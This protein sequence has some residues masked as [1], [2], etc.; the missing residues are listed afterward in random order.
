MLQIVVAENGRVKQV[1]VY[2]SS[3]FALL[4]NAARDTVKNWR[5]VPGTENG[6]PETTEVLVP[7]HFKLQ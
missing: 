1:T 3:G 4:D 7:I 5:F 2:R 6:H